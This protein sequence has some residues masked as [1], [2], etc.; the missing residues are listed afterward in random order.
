MCVT[1]V[2]KESCRT[3][4]ANCVDLHAGGAGARVAGSSVHDRWFEDV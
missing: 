2:M 1:V 4:P 3:Y